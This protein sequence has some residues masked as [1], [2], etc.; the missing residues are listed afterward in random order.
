[1]R[2]KLGN[3]VGFSN[4]Y[5]TSTTESSAVTRKFVAGATSGTWELQRS[6]ST[7]CMNQWG[8]TG[9][10]AK[11]GE[12]NV[13]DPNNPMYF[14]EVETTYLEPVFSTD[15]HETYFM[16]QFAKNGNDMA[17]LGTGNQ[18][19]VAAPSTASTH[20]WKF[21]GNAS[22]FQIVC[23]DG[24]YIN[25]KSNQTATNGQTGDLLVMSSTCLL[26]TSPSPRDRG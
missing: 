4:S 1:M 15:G 24:N 9:V 11:L 14:N 16:I 3:Y 6:G 26:Y 12:W 22:N 5:F 13:N 20:L 7:K 25:V 21:V 2:S 18:A 23:K 17:S 8:G 10:G 19:R